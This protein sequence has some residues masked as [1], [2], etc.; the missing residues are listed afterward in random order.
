[1]ISIVI[2]KFAIISFKFTA[3]WKCGFAFSS[4]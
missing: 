2:V 1:M 4:S 3:G